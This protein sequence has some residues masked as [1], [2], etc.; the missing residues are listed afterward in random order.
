MG[1]KTEL[2]IIICGFSFCILVF[3]A[4]FSIM[5]SRGKRHK[6]KVRTLALMQGFQYEKN[7][8]DS[9]LRDGK[10]CYPF[11]YYYRDH[12]RNIK[13]KVYHVI[14]KTQAN[15]ITTTICDYT[16]GR[17]SKGGSWS[18]Y[19]Y[20]IMLM[21]SPKI[22]LPKFLCA[23]PDGI[24]TMEKNVPGFENVIEIPQLENYII[25]GQDKDSICNLLDDR[26]VDFLNR[27]PELIIE[28]QDGVLLCYYYKGDTN[29][30][31]ASITD[32][33]QLVRL[34]YEFIRLF[35]PWS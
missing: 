25:R 11:I 17:V 5:I 33:E 23:P 24:P 4:I 20:T 19:S 16:L 10:D 29:W 14:R 3:G 35:C 28:G 32:W 34:E 8:Q 26:A 9:V 18:H 12:T 21:T 7:D 30:N 27:N 2:L 15:D 1:D 22:K 6:K 13:H 31:F